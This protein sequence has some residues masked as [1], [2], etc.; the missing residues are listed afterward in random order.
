MFPDDDDVDDNDEEKE[1][2]EFYTTE[3]KDKNILKFT[4]TVCQPV[5][6]AKRGL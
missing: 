5:A 4:G 2:M 1:D 6:H 3:F